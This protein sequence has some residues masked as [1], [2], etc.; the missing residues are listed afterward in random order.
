MRVLLTG[1]NG[2]VGAAVA[3]DLIAAGHAVVGLVRSAGKGKRLVAA[4]GALLVGS[5]GDLDVLRRGADGADGVIHPAF[6]LYLSQMKTLAAEDSRAI[7]AI[8][9]VLARSGRP[10]GR[11]ARVPAGDRARI[12]GR[13][14]SCDRRAGDRIPAHR[15]GARAAAEPARAIAA[16]RSRRRP[17][18]SAGTVGGR[19][20]PCIERVDATGAGL[21]ARAAGADC[22]HRA[23]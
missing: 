3:D 7:E 5:L 13:S 8:G 6:G 12:A 1:A 11:G 19:Q 4:G 23:A 22:G 17:F 9:A 14:L 2:W 18:R 15:R 10:A 21:A 20:R 16:G